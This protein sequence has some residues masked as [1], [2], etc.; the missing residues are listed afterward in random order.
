M[1]LGP[2]KST[3]GIGVANRAS[4]PLDVSD[5]RVH[6]EAVREGVSFQCSKQVGAAQP[7]REPKVLGPGASFVFERTLDCALPLVGTYAVRV[8]VSFGRGEWARPHDVHAFTMRVF[9][10]PDVAPRSVDPLPG[11]WGAVG[12]G[13]VLFGDTGR[14]SGRIVVALVNGG[15]TPLELPRF[16]LA[17]RV[18]RVG[19]LIPCEEEPMELKT[20]AVLAAGAAHDEPIEVSC[21]GLGVPGK[22]EVLARLQ[23]GSRADHPEIELGRLRIEISNDPT[24]RFPLLPSPPPLW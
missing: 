3:L 14:G 4:A 17:L 9:A 8:A 12:A 18:F 22:Y 1:T 21:L 24:R 16:R 5:L 15:R 6:L 20:P 19:T 2:T 23:I 11:L 10:T 7:T 13:P